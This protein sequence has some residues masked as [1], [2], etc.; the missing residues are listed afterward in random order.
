M[1]IFQIS[2][3]QDSQVVITNEQLKQTNLLFNRLELLEKVDSIN[4][5]KI[6][7]LMEANNVLKESLE[8]VELGLS[9][10]DIQN[11]K[12]KDE[13]E[14]LNSDLKKARKAVIGSSIVWV[15]L[16]ALIILI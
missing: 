15:G 16:F 8:S 4:S 6:E 10:C 5:L 2:Y 11:Q 9:I 12:L 14:K 7:N 1:S 13:N 3:A